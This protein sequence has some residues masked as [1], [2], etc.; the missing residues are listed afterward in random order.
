MIGR[1]G[2][3]DRQCAVTWDRIDPGR[4]TRY[5]SGDERIRVIR[6][7]AVPD[8]VHRN[9][10]EDVGVTGHQTLEVNRAGNDRH[11][12]DPLEQI[13]NVGCRNDVPADR[14]TIGSRLYEG[15]LR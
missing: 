4:C 7:V 6:F 11:A 13:S 10:R 5:A 1:C 3:S 8:G 15:H 9:G 2:P 12:L 14:R